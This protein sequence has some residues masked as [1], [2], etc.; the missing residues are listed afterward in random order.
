MSLQNIKK[1][2]NINFASVNEQLNAIDVLRALGCDDELRMSD[3]IRI[4]CTIHSSDKQKSLV[5]TPHKNKFMCHACNAKGDLVDLYAQSKHIEKRDAAFE[6]ASVFNI[7][8]NTPQKEKTISSFNPASVT[9]IDG[10]IP[11]AVEAW[12]KA[13]SGDEHPYLFNKGVGPCDGLKF[14]ADEKGNHSVVIPFKDIHGHLRAVQYVNEHAKIFATGS[15]FSSA[16][17]HVGDLDDAEK[18]YITEGIATML[19]VWNA[20]DMEQTVIMCGSKNNVVKVVEAIRS[21]YIHTS[22]VV[23]L[24]RDA[25]DPRGEKM[26]ESIKHIPSVS[27]VMPQFPMGENESS[28]FNDVQAT[29]GIAEVNRQLQKQEAL[30]IETNQTKEEAAY[31]EKYDWVFKNNTLEELKEDL[32]NISPAISTGYRIQDY[33]DELGTHLLKFPG[34]SLTVI[35]APT[36]HGKTTALINFSQGVIRSNPG[37]S[38]YF[39]SYEESKAKVLMKHLNTAIDLEI[40]K[41]NKGAILSL[42]HI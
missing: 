17:F 15:K 18:I 26:K 3:N 1:N 24:E 40:A 7:N 5:V 42:I 36:N 11:A 39:F 30:P 29:F 25:N 37:K 16:F 8:G 22:I 19:T 28:D 6:L 23:C 34:G 27:T 2:H 12:N 13:V 35:A 14:G 33:D 20:F 21:K 32:R 41:N 31:N 10:D 38:V 9:T 4:H